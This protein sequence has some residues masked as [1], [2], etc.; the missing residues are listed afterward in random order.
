MDEMIIR[1]SGFPFVLAVLF[2]WQLPGAQGA[3]TPD[4]QTLIAHGQKALS[5]KQYDAAEQDFTQLLQQGVRTAPV[6]SNL[7]VVYLR[8]GKI[9][10]AVEMLG[11]AEKLAP[12]FAGIHL[13]LGLAYLREHE[14]KLAS[15]SFG[16]VVA[17]EPNHVQAR[18]LKGLCDFMTDDFQGTVNSLQPIMEQE[19]DDLEYLFM[20]GISYGMLKRNEDAERTFARLIEAGG[21]TPHLHLLLGKAYLALGQLS[22]ADKE[23]QLAT[24]G[25]ALPYAHYYRG[26]LA[27]KQE[28]TDEAVEQ[29][30]QEVALVPN[31]PWA[32]KELA[33]IK[34]DRDDFAGAIALLEK[35]VANN[36]ESAD[37]YATLGR[38]YL[39]SPDTKHAVSMLKKAISLDPKSGMYHYQLA[40]A[41]LAEGRRQ[42]AETEKQKARSLMSGDSQGKMEQFSRGSA[43]ASAPE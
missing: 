22:E 30:S 19:K 14:F 13:N 40:Q 33:T 21:N 36:P 23:L 27:Q 24:K 1:R 37:L 42:E 5:E 25:E 20:L 16:E 39:H 4:T 35:G 34:M 31:N 10:K 43:A 15:K 12:S 2:F 3:Q 18:Y 8:L 26:V 28:K 17:M 29:F 11:K 6:Y 32:Y 9:D 41:Y 38:A 7:G